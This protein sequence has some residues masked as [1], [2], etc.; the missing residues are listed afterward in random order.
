MQ[1][2]Q[3]QIVL[4]IVL[5]TNILYL[6]YFYTRNMQWQVDVSVWAENEYSYE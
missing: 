4:Y 1:I 5:A 6:Y 3:L 2:L